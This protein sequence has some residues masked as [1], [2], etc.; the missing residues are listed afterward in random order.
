VEPERSWAI[1][2]AATATVLG[3]FGSSYR[4]ELGDSAPCPASDA[5]VPLEA[6]AG[7]CE[8]CPLRA[9]RRR[10]LHPSFEGNVPGGA[11]DS[12][13]GRELADCTQLHSGGRGCA[14]HWRRVDPQGS[15]SVAA[16][17]SNC[18]IGAPVYSRRQQRSGI[19]TRRLQQRT[20]ARST[21]GKC[22]IQPLQALPPEIGQYWPAQEERLTIAIA[23]GIL[24]P[25]ILS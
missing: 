8:S 25:G 13:W 12:S 3:R 24:R 20:H 15:H 18:R 21:A 14:W 17:E 22:G 19:A 9:C 2:A 6:G 5:A 4:K 7:F 1:G 10:Q 11:V 16:T 23:K